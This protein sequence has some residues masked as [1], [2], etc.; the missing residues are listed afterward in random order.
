MLGDVSQ[1]MVV[2][3]DIW[4]LMADEGAPIT[5][6]NM[7]SGVHTGHVES[8]RGGFNALGTHVVLL[9]HIGCSLKTR[10]SS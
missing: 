7:V 2:S 10:V 6:N 1:R 3:P 5:G 9:Y 4:Q 8:G